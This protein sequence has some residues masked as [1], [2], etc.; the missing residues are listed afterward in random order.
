MLASRRMTGKRGLQ[1][2]LRES[3]CANETLKIS[4]G[5]ES[6]LRWCTP[7]DLVLHDKKRGR[8]IYSCAFQ[9]G[10]PND[11][12]LQGRIYKGKRPQVVYRRMTRPVIFETRPE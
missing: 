6:G 11:L 2:E 8:H 1:D 7:H 5:T 9:T 4:A 3:I 12:T 10:P